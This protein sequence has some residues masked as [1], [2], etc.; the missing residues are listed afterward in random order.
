MNDQLLTFLKTDLKNIC[1]DPMLILVLCV[2]ILMY[3]LVTFGLPW[4]DIELA[5][6]IPFSLIDHRDFIIAMVLIMTPAMMGMA[7]GFLLLDEKDDGILHYMG[8]T[9]LKK[10][11]YLIYRISLPAGLAFVTAVF[12]AW[13][14][15]NPSQ[16]NW[17]NFLLALFLNAL[18]GS[19]VTMYLAVLARNKV[20]GMAYAKLIALFMV[21][22]IACYLIDSPWTGFTYLIPFTWGTEAVLSIVAVEASYGLIQ[23][24]TLILAGGIMVSLLWSGCFFRILLRKI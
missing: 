20:E 2:P 8:I 10:W 9:P 18:I 6:Y 12:Q 23:N 17:L 22:P 7:V 16:I 19:L 5:S 24:P 15:Y 11:G 21:A 1:R 4:L 3:G 13:T 14:F